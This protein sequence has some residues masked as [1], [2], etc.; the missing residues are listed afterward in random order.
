M[1]DALPLSYGQT[2]ASLFDM[3]AT[4]WQWPSPDSGFALHVFRAAGT[5]LPF[6]VASTELSETHRRRIGEGPVVATAGYVLAG[7]G[8]DEDLQKA[9]AAGLARLTAR[10]PF[11][12]DRES[13][14]YRPLELLGICLGLGASSGVDSSHRR[15]L[16]DSLGRGSD[17]LGDSELWAQLLA[18][19]AAGVLGVTWH[20]PRL[21]RMHECGLEELALL[22]WL[23]MAY[24]GLPEVLGLGGRDREYQEAL[25]LQTAL[26]SLPHFDVS[27]AAVVYVALAVL[28]E[29]FIRSSTEHYWQV[30][31]SGR[32]AVELVRTLC[33]RFRL[34]ALQIQKRYNQRQTICF[35]DEH[36]VQDVMHALLRLHFDD[37]RAEEW[38]PSYAGNASRTDFLLK[39]EQVIVETMVTR[40]KSRKLDQREITTQIIIDKERY[41]TPPNCKTL[42]CFV[43]DPDHVCDNAA[44][45][46]SDVSSE[47]PPLRLVVVAAPSGS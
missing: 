24:P 22:V 30:G 23:H 33:S 9:W 16:L 18:G 36:D 32:D 34:F 19:C 43:Y 41:R 15:W 47:G 3:M 31:R 7:C 4:Q 38:T 10:Q 37:V 6:D 26:G 39:R 46:E 25:L 2:L 45:L 44:A 20:L 35:E 13:F 27:R 17:H 11:P 5:E 29:R 40:T 28:I 14:F 1:S 12:R 8:A 42:V 21:P